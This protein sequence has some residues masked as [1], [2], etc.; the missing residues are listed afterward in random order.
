MEFFKNILRMFTA[1]FM[2]L[3]FLYGARRTR[4]W[5]KKNEKLQDETFH[6]YEKRWKYIVKKAKTFTKA[7]GVNVKVINEENK[8][9]G[10]YLLISNHSSN[11]DGFYLLPVLGEKAP[12]TAIAKNTLEDSTVR[13][14]FQASETFFVFPNN[15]R[16]SLVNFGRAGEWAKN[17]KRGVVIFPEGKRNW[18]AELGEFHAASFKIAQRNY[19][20]IH[21]ITIL[22]TI[23]ARKWYKFNSREVQIIFHKPIKASEVMRISTEK[24]SEK[25]RNIINAPLLEYEK[26]FQGKELEKHNKEKERLEKKQKNFEEKLEV[27]VKK[28]E[29]KNK[30]EE[31]KAKAKKIKKLNK[32][33][34][35]KKTNSKKNKK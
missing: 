23:E 15:L 24:L 19:L 10:S 22:G 13:G 34:K 25:V 31:E 32:Q 2:Y 8:P 5:M 6:D 18:N 20:P 1:P 30:K 26:Q 3:N 12:A 7:L 33:T 27:K 4:K 11:F 14:Y 16:K 29:A 17:N 9:K 35:S 28:L 21:P